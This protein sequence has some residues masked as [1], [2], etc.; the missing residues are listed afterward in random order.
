MK[1]FRI[2]AVEG[3]IQLALHRRERELIS[4]QPRTQV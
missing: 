4:S 2:E 3:A 1:P